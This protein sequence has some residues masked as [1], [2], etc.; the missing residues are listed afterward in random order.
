VLLFF[1]LLLLLLTV[2]LLHFHV[3][4]SVQQFEFLSVDQHLCVFY[5]ELVV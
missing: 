3:L 1:F 5:I 4:V 2:L